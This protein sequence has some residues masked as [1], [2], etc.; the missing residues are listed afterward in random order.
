VINTWGVTRPIQEPTRRRRSRGGPTRVRAHVGCDRTLIASSWPHLWLAVACRHVEVI[1]SGYLIYL[2]WNRPFTSISR[3]LVSSSNTHNIILELHLTPHLVF[4]FI[5]LVVVFGASKSYL[6]SLS[7]WKKELLGMNYMKSSSIFKLSSHSY[8]N[9][10]E[11]EYSC[12]HVIIMIYELAYSLNVMILTCSTLCL[13]IHITCMS[14]IKAKL[15][16]W[17]IMPSGVPKSFTYWSIGSGTWGDLGSFYV[18]KHGA[19]VWRNGWIHFPFH[20]WGVGGSGD[21]PVRPL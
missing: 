14:R 3:G 17:F 4:F 11:L 20:G 21:S 18:C 7:P 19:W 5:V 16:W 9:A 1:P 13:I 2:C 15:R 6:E 10:Y 12:L 8:S